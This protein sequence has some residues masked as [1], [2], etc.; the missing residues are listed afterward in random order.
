[1]ILIVDDEVNGRETLRD[2]LEDEG[3]EV[4]CASD[5]G[6]ALNKLAN[7]RPSLMILDLLM[8]GMNGNALYDEMQKSPILA[9]I[10]IVVT[11]SDPT[12]APIGVPTLGKP[13]RLDKVLSVVA[14]ACGRL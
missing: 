14:L 4:I 8:P 6:D 1:V 2:L 11:T 13:L 3:Y 7:A 9:R 5:G 10:P 12:R